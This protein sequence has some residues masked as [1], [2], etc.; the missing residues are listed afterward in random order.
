MA[1]V[2]NYILSLQENLSAK[3][4][5]IGVNSVEALDS[6]AELERQAQAVSRRMDTMGR[7]VT[8]LR[9]KLSLLQNERDLIP[10]SNIT[11]IRRYNAEIERLSR[12]I[13]RLETTTGGGLRKGF[14]NAFNQIPYAN[15]IT[16][17]LVA[18]GT[19][20]FASIK[21]GM[22]SETVQVAFD[23]LLGDSDKARQ[24]IQQ[25]K[26][27][28]NTSPY[29]SAEIQEG[30]KTMLSFGIAQQKIMP[31]MKAIGDIA[32]GDK[33]KLSALTLAF[34]QMSSTGKLTG[35]DL[36]Q[37]I[38]VGF[39]PLNEIS[40]KTGKSIGVLKDKMGKGMISAQMVSDAFMS[41]TQAGGQFYGMAEK[42]GKTLAGRLATMQ[43]QLSEVLL[44]VYEMIEPILKPAVEGLSRALKGLQIVVGGVVRFMQSWWNKIEEGVNIVSVLSV[45]LGG[46]IAGL[47]LY[48]TWVGVVSVATK[49]WAGVQALLNVVM[50][51]NPIGL[52]IAGVVALIAVIAYVC[53]KISG[54]GSLWKGTIEG[55]KN[56]MLTFVDKVKAD[57]TGMVNTLM[58]GI[59]KI[60]ESWYKFKEAVGIGSSEENQ[61]AIKKIQA[62]T[63]ARKKAIVDAYKKVD[64]DVKNVKESFGSIELKWDS[65]KKL[66]DVTAGIKNKLGVGDNS[67][68]SQLQ[69]NV[70][71]GGTSK[72]RGSSQS[73]TEKS[74]VTGGQR[75]TNINIT[76]KSLVENMVLNENLKDKAKEVEED[77]ADM[78]MRVLNIAQSTVS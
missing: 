26:D 42:Q 56:L 10:E 15:L 57:F 36:L 65:G 20:A 77:F 68:N 69:G 62:D 54:W 45:V 5:Q 76:I 27:Y 78:M 3:L 47:V 18:A 25:T 70:D 51:A 71:I 19:T 17:P 1:N 66:S 75:S 2:L 6:F 33:N 50:T 58:I 14:M 40:K 32:M 64:K 7:S 63:E 73:S 38:N 72:G 52:I 39:N 60:K 44:S 12:E 31:T 29:N 43:G 16:N 35:Q 34:S 59:N 8:T 49:I 30:A 37:M 74:I 23:V 41:A 53:Y 4:R 9:E 28:A 22:E 55:M 24:M 48:N 46:F 61:N 11:A 13:S 21:K 67:V